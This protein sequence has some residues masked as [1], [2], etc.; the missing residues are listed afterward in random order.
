[1]NGLREYA[2]VTTVG[3][4]GI[5]I[6]PPTQLAINDVHPHIGAAKVLVGLRKDAM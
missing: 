2:T 3:T 1:M 5:G 6:R 4:A